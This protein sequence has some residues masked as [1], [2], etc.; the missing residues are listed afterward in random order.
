M[1]EEIRRRRKRSVSNN[2]RSGKAKTRANIPVAPESGKTR[3]KVTKLDRDKV[4][5]QSKNSLARPERILQ[6][7]QFLAK[8]EN[9]NRKMVVKEE[10][11]ITQIAI[12]EDDILVENFV[13]SDSENYIS[14]SV[15]YGKVQNVLPSMEAAFV[16]IGASKNG[17]LYAGEV[18]YDIADIQAAE[19]ET[20]D[21]ALKVGDEIL[22]QVTKE[23]FGKKGARL[24]SEITLSG[25]FLVLAPSRKILGISRKLSDKEKMRI[26][27]IIRDILPKDM[28]VI[29]RTVA[30]GASYDDFKNDLDN[31]LVQ[32][33]EIKQKQ[34]IAK[35]PIQIHSEPNLEIRIIR[36]Y[37][38]SSFSEIII[39]G[40]DKIYNDI[41]KYVSVTSP[42]LK[43]RV[44]KA[45][46]GVDIF[47]S[48]RIG[49][50]LSKALARI[51]HLPSGGS[52]VIDKTEAM[53]VID[54]N[55]SKFTGIKGQTLEET[56]TANNLEAAQEIVNQMRIRDLGGIIVVDFIDM[57]LEE[58]RNLVLKRLVECLSRDRTVHQV[59]E[60]TSLGL[61]QI[62]RKR[63]G[64]SLL[65]VFSEVCQNCH[66]DGYII[67]TRG[68]S[69]PEPIMSGSVVETSE[70][71]KDSLKEIF[72]AAKEADVDEADYDDDSDYDETD[73]IDMEIDIEYEDK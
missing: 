17:V 46:K 44:S 19:V 7:A 2:I 31:L 66:G 29:I 15:F 8:R 24:T 36:D 60:I 64:R 22:V 49:E 11:N 53:T 16:D 40:S 34:T 62:T 9:V 71:T 51:V 33:K 43:N 45:S 14:G 58:N 12:L 23:P 39:S 42:D 52:L 6:N 38:N 25:H 4:V 13:S 3:I 1:A 37:F 68:D 48:M 28:G 41:Y 72:R 26:K 67:N 56:V 32:W 47:K 61:V 69:I 50:Q 21:K 5:R 10:N 55:T 20:I 30:E 63:V 54:V 27:K 73:E 57:I 18:N 70:K 65:D 59:T 35:A